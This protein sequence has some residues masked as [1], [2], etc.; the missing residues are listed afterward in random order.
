MISRRWW[1][2][3]TS[4][5]KR[6]PLRIQF[7]ITSMP[8][9][10]AETLLV[11]MLRRMDPGIVLPEVVCLKERGPLGDSIAEE[12]TVHSDLIGGKW[13]I[14]VLLRLSRLMRRRNVDAVITVGAGDKMF[15]GRLAAFVAGVPVIASALHS[16]GWPDG[17]G[18]LNRILTPMTDAFIAVAD[19]HGEFLNRFERFPKS[20][21]HVIRNGV[22]CERFAPSDK[23]R[24]D[25]RTEL[26]LDVNTP[27]VGI[28][29]ALRS[30]KNHALLVRAAAKL[31]DRHPDLHWM[32]VGDG[33]ERERIEQLAEELSVGDR[34]HLLGTR[35][36]TPRLVSALDVFTLCSLNEASPVS[37]LEALS[38][39]VP[40]AATDVGSVS[41]S[42]VA[43]QT[44]V[45]FESQDF[46]GMVQAI[47]G[48]LDDPVARKRYGK[49]GRELVLRSG[50]LESMV[51]GYQCLVTSL[52]DRACAEPSAVVGRAGGLTP[53]SDSKG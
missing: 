18:R 51:A 28:V 19:S 2:P 52:Y 45:L 49:T 22:D 25:V 17:V 35:H 33:P 3:V 48:L 24:A 34:I 15:W 50:S 26:G 41:E 23:N 30:E 46:N 32:V 38:S 44:G 12:F 7:V 39:E 29:A 21:V 8:V 16:T 20:K 4:R 31:R 47:G 14:G 42:I 37:I 9:G 36:D 40:V 10:G 43:G 13:D 53:V 11:N 6:G 27:L 5:A 1:R